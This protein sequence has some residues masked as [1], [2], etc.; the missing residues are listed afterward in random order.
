M[1]TIK[2]T[3]AGEDFIRS[4]CKGSGNSKLRGSAVDKRGYRN[5]PTAV[6]PYCSPLTTTSKIWISN[7]DINGGI[8]TNAELAEELIRL[9]NKYAVMYQL[10]ANILAAQ[11]Y[12]ESLFIIWNYAV[13]SSASGISQFI[14][15]AV[16][17]VIIRNAYGGFTSAER[18]AIT[19]DLNGYVYSSGTP[20]KDPFLVDYELGRKNRPILHQNIIDNLEIM[21]KAQFVYMNFI[22]TRC[23]KLASVTLFGYS[24]GP[25][26]LNE[27]SSSYSL[28]VN[29]AKNRGN[30]YE[31]EGIH[32][33]YKIFTNLYKN[34]GYKHLNMTKEAVTTFDRFNATLG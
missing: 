22:S 5:N 30:S 26:L 15:N 1:A 7:P 32:Y 29:A 3:K 33:V 11:A 12:Q 16:Y 18:Q 17:D 21:I 6:L 24:R 14:A 2:L 20:P 10:D 23:N 27:P 13:N 9:Y 19:K 4:V 8:T 31:D 25:Y 28:W 34:F